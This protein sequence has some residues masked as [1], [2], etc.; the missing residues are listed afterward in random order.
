MVRKVWGIEEFRR[1]ISAKYF[2][3]KKAIISKQKFFDIMQFY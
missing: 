2:P 1:S 3:N